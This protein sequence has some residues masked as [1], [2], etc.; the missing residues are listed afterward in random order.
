MGFSKLYM[1]SLF[2][3]FFETFLQF[4]FFFADLKELSND[5]SFVIFGHQTW[6]LEGRWV[7]FTQAGRGLITKTC[8]VKDKHNFY[9]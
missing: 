4:F 3:L 1:F 9:S 7:K 6:D 8:E 2:G 5:A